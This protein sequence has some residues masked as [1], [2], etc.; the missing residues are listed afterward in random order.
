M[1]SLKEI[2]DYVQKT[3]EIIASVLDLQVIIC[4][5]NRFIIGDSYPYPDC[6][7]IETTSILAKVIETGQE[8]IL[9][10]VHSQP[11]CITC[12]NRDR[13]N[14]EAIVGSPI[15]Y[16]D[17]IIGVIGILADTVKSKNMLME[18]QDSYMDFIHRMCDLLVIKIMEWEKNIEL[19]LIQ[20]QLSCIINTI[21]S[22]LIATDSSGRIIHF[23]T[24]IT[25]FIEASIINKEVLNIK[26]LFDNSFINNLVDNGESFRNK[27]MVIERSNGSVYALLSGKEIAYENR[28]IGSILLFKKMS[29]V[30]RDID[31]L[32][33]SGI[34]SSFDTVIGTSS[35]ILE[36][37][38]KAAMIAR[39]TSTVLILGESGTGKELFARAIHNSSSVA[40]MP[41]IALNCAAIPESLLESEL[42]GYEEG[43]FSGAK[44]GGK[45]GKFQLANGGTLFLDEI[46]EMPIHLQTK[47]LRVL[48]ERA[49]EPLGGTISIPI[50]VRVIAATNK[51]LHELMELKKFREDLYYRLNV[52]PLMIPPL[53]ERKG[54]IILL[55]NHFLNLYNRKLNRNIQGFSLDVEKIMVSH[56]WKGNVRE[57]QNVIEYAVN[58]SD[59][60]IIR[61]K[62][63]IISPII[64]KEHDNT[65]S[66]VIET[67]DELLEKQIIDVLKLY[68]TSVQGKNLAAKAL[69]ISLSTLYRKMKH[70]KINVDSRYFE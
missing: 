52:I 18:K 6:N 39:G 45:I 5:Y 56:F 15:I 17:H 61:L 1:I 28:N 48:Q 25:D 8:L 69:G 53:R 20:Q 11:G 10:P 31:D 23:N 21:D 64:Q 14:I 42:F 70:F 63:I 13:C 26:D 35:K 16:N 34:I 12:K 36:V 67:M 51:D 59:G 65:D 44:K 32:S 4:D 27:E 40:S 9:Y 54:D 3:A 30:H 33:D 29:D 62:D 24:A 7:S 57:L 38:N 19:K 66:A 58:M 60:D 37:K 41:F 46:G 22:G 2:Q 68:G 47:L 43:A 50:D 55:M 49:I